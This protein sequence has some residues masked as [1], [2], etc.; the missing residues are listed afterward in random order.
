MEGTAAPIRVR[1]TYEVV[2]W[3][4]GDGQTALRQAMTAVAQAVAITPGVDRHLIYLVDKAALAQG[5]EVPLA[6]FLAAVGE[7]ARN[8]SLG[9]PAGAQLERA[10]AVAGAGS[11]AVPGPAGQAGS[12]ELT[13]MI[14]SSSWQRIPV[15]AILVVPLLAVVL[16]S[17]PAWVLWPFLDMDRLVDWVKALNGPRLSRWDSDL[18]E[19]CLSCCGRLW[20]PLPGTRRPPSRPAHDQSLRARSPVATSVRMSACGRCGTVTPIG[21]SVTARRS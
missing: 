2:D 15:A 19:G 18:R 7:V 3:L 5:L 12:G 10:L 17:S 1:A 4:L 9:Y 8:A 20:A 13:V 14:P 16:L 6:D 11:R 21:R